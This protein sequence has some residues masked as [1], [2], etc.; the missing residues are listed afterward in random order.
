M[1]I[2]RLAGS[3]EELQMETVYVSGW[4]TGRKMG[5]LRFPEV[6]CALS[7]LRRLAL[8]NHQQITAIPADISSLQEL[9]DLDLHR[10][11]LY[12]LPKELGELS[13]LTRLDLMSNRKL[14]RLPAELGKLKSLREL[15]LSFCDLRAVPADIG[16]LE[17]LEVL[18]LSYNDHLQI[19]APLDFLVEGCPRLREVSICKARYRAPWTPESLEHLEAFKAKLGAH[20]SSWYGF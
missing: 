19:H 13:R 5:L 6:F 16:E 14:W 15:V 9:E 4:H 8:D 7:K 1:P 17:S 10:C 12:S 20:V 11:D 2:V 18:S 3:L